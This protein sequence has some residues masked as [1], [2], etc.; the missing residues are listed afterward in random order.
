MLEYLSSK[1]PP[2]RGVGKDAG[3]KN[4]CTLLVEMQGSTTTL[5]NNMEAS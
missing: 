1:T 3:K 4:P 2:T 5:E